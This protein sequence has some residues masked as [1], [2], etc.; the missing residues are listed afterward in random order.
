MNKKLLKYLSCPFCAGELEISKNTVQ[1]KDEVMYGLITCTE[2]KSRYPIIEGIPVMMSSEK[3]LNVFAQT[4]K[5]GVVGWGLSVLDICKHLEK[6]E[7]DEIRN[8]VIYSIPY[9]LYTLPRYVDKF[10]GNIGK[11][12]VRKILRSSYFDQYWTKSAKNVLENE[13]T[14]AY[15]AMRVYYQDHELFNYFFYKFGQPRFLT[16]LNLASI[17]ESPGKPILDLACGQ[18]HLI[19][20]ITKKNTKSTII[21]LDRNFFQLYLAKKYIAPK[22]HYICAEADEKLPF[23]N[24]TFSNIICADAFHYFQNKVS[25]TRDLKEII[26]T[27]GTIILNRVGNQNVEPNEGTE[28]TPDG[29]LKLFNSMEVKIAGENSL[30]DSYL[31][32]QK[33]NLSDVEDSS[34]LKNQK[35]LTIIASNNNQIFKDHG[36]FEEWPHCIGSLALNPH[37]AKVGTD[38]D[39]DSRYKF[40][41]PTDWYEY[42]N[43]L[44][45]NY[46]PLEVTIS[47]DL[48]RS[49]SED[50]EDP[51]IDKYIDKFVVLGFPDNYK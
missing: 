16:T 18:G 7:I 14:T 49:L 9:K 5:K 32:K 24:N 4:R 34:H 29:Y 41:Y 6:N 8:S 43:S 28:L 19:H 23:K 3:S 13:K 2:C 15:E 40:T 35:W 46:A 37:Y 27:D 25:C 33:P 51:N 44:L 38:N 12:I 36:H 21:G 1:D 45:E 17:I 47:E 20:F 50:R 39:G 22:G 26:A 11:R 30:L 10:T 31:N 48:L 42:E